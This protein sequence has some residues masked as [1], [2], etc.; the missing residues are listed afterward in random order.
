MISFFPHI[1]VWRSTLEN[2]YLSPPTSN[3]ATKP[4]YKKLKNAL[5]T[6]IHS[7]KHNYHNGILKIRLE[8]NSAQLGSVLRNL[9]KTAITISTQ[10]E[11]K[12]VKSRLYD[13]SLIYLSTKNIIFAWAD[14]YQ[15]IGKV[16]PVLCQF[17]ATLLLL[18]QFFS[19]KSPSKIIP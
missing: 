12:L 4:Q 19:H 6:F 8:H 15:V 2:S 10:F 7:I 13:N 16:S 5:K 11:M 1:I 17:I 3:W 14:H 18:S 9:S